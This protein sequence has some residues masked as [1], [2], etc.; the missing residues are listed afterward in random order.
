M[1]S[2]SFALDEFVGEFTGDTDGLGFVGVVVFWLLLLFVDG[3]DGETDLTIFAV[4]PSLLNNGG[5]SCCGVAL[6]G[7]IG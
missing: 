5:G 1:A 6:A 3:V 4:G 7:L 2:S